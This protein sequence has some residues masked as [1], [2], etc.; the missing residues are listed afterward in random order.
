MKN[1]F[2][3]LLSFLSLNLIAQTA[4]ETE[5]STVKVYKQQA[6]ITRKVSSKLLAGKQEIILTGIS[7]SINPASLQVQIDGSPNIT[8]LSAKYE[9]NY[10]LPVKQNPEIENLKTR[11]YAHKAW[12]YARIVNNACIAYSAEYL[13]KDEVKKINFFIHESMNEEIQKEVNEYLDRIFKEIL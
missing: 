8:L 2:I 9:R 12:D 3:I 11:E 10:L 5:I 1:A 13:S 6:E 7:T 4:L